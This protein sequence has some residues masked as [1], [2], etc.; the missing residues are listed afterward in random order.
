MPDHDRT[1][2]S[3][4]VHYRADTTGD[5]RLLRPEGL[6][7]FVA[8]DLGEGH[9]LLVDNPTDIAVLMNHLADASRRL[10]EAGL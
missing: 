9:A 4:T 1:H 7:P 3:V 5:P 2:V 6:D 10:M 8:V